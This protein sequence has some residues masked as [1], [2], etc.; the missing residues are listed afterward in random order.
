MRVVMA[1]HGIFLSVGSVR[2]KLTQSRAREPYQNRNPHS[3]QTLPLRAS[4]KARGGVTGVELKAKRPTAGPVFLSVLVA[5]LSFRDGSQSRTLVR[6][7]APE[8]LEIPGLVLRTIP[9]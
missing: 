2:G 9:E 8:N 3:R 5:T 7:C 6:N 1:G 4:R